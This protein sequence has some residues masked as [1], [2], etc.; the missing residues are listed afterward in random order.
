MANELIAH[1]GGDS[2]GLGK[3]VDEAISKLKGFEGQL[4]KVVDASEKMKSIGK[5]LSLSVTAPIVAMGTLSAK[6]FMNFEQSMAGVRAITGATAEEFDASEKS[7]KRLGATTRYSASKV[8]ELQTDLAK[9][10]FDPTAINAATDGILDLAVAT[11]E[12][13]ADS[14]RVTAGV[15]RAFGI[16]TEK[17]GEV[18]DV[19]AKAFTATKLDLQKFDV[20]MA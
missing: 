14:A 1:I 13:L 17:T 19:M 2:S 15:L 4:K 11:S 20:A 7:A 10:G 12:D 5:T 16:E 9:L 6:T 8:A 3:A 18:A